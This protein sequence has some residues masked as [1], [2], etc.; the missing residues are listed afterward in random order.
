MMLAEGGESLG[1]S[2]EKQAGLVKAATANPVE[3]LRYE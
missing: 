3:R 2:L 1:S